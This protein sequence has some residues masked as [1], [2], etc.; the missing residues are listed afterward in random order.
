MFVILD[1][2]SVMI[3]VIIHVRHFSSA[4][5]GESAF[6][7]LTEV[8]VVNSVSVVVVT[9]QNDLTDQLLDALRLEGGT[10]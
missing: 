9:S 1:C 5:K 2:D 3:F 6:R 4:S 7:V 8:D 10:A